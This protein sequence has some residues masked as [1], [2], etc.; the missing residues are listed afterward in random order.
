MTRITI[1][2]FAPSTYTRSARM[3]AIELGFEHDLV[4]VAYGK[5]EHLALH[6]FGK[7]P[8]MTIGETTV[9]E[10]LAIMSWLDNESPAPGIFG[11]DRKMRADVV[12]L[13]S[14]AIDYAYRPVVHITVKDGEPDPNQM[15]EADRVL[16]WLETRT[17][18]GSF[19]AGDRVTAADFFFAPMIAYHANQVGEDRAYRSRPGLSQWMGRMAARRSFQE[20]A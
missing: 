8:A 12:T 11:A 19:L 14:V 6:P 18:A 3:A 16:D 5:P 2:G 17:R 9:F 4:P 20:T 10:T 7:M 15:A 1:H 13:V